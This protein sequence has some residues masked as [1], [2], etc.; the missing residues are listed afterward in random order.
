[1]TGRART[2]F[3]LTDT[4]ALQLGV[5]VAT[6]TNT[7]DLYTTLLGFDVKYKYRPEGWLHPLVTVASEGIYSFRKVR[8]DV[9]EDT[10]G[11][12]VADTTVTDRRTRDRFGW[13][14]YGEVQ[15]WRRWSLGAR[16]D[17][18]QYPTDPGR[19]WAFGPYVTYWPS[20]FLRFRLGYK[21]TERTSQTRDQ[22]NLNGGSAR[23]VDEVM[24]QASF[25]LGAHPAHPF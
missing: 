7:D 10:D 21:H 13:Y 3:E 5:S 4:S 20:E 25:I 19:E 9:E 6:G 18:T 24:F 17:N 12:G 16:Y 8:V 1:V 11:D 2:F 15:P 22:F 23:K 14:L